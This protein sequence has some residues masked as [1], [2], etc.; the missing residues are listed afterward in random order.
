MSPLSALLDYFL[1]LV[2]TSTNEAKSHAD[3]E[4]RFIPVGGSALSNDEPTPNPAL[5]VLPAASKLLLPS[6][7][8]LSEYKAYTRASSGGLTTR[9]SS[10]VK[11][12]GLRPPRIPKCAVSPTVVCKGVCE[13][14]GDDCR[15][16]GLRR[17]AEV[18][19]V[20]RRRG[21]CVRDVIKTVAL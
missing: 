10:P 5:V 1:A 6:V 14:Y 21:M 19:Q 20:T 13:E 18:A 11:C 4:I 16:C 8:Q 7:A 12:S 3:V 15:E 2:S 9:G 17:A